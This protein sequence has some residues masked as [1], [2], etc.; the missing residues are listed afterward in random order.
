MSDRNHLYL[1]GPMSGVEDYNFPAFHQSAA[2]LR[3]LGYEVTNPAELDDG[4][5][6]KPWDEYLRRDLKLMLDCDAVAVLPGW[7]ES[8]GARLETHVARAPEMPVFPLHELVPD[9]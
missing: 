6:T 1:A 4:D 3:A 8:R 5:T 2:L 9:E 7:E